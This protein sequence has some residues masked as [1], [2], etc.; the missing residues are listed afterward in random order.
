MCIWKVNA[1]ERNC[2]YCSYRGG[3]E[4]YE[5]VTPVEEAG[6][7]Y[8]SVMNELLGRDILERSRERELVW[9][10]YMVCYRLIE[11]GYTLGKTGKFMN[12][13]HATVLHGKRQVAN[14]LEMPQMFREE[15]GLWKKFTELLSLR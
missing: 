15:I 1:S 11:D 6:A 8:V 14:M 3:C 7:V 2:D 12:L 9:A 4:S 10:R 13:D 5:K